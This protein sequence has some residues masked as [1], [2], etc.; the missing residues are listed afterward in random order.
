MSVAGFCGRYPWVILSVVA[1]ALLTTILIM[2]F[3]F[4]VAP[5][6]EH[7]TIGFIILGDI[8]EPGWNASQYAGITSACKELGL[9]LHVRDHV[10]EN[11]GQCPAAIRELANLGCDMIFLCSYTYAKEALPMVQAFPHI[12]FATVGAEVHTANLTAYFVRMYQAR[13]LSGV[14][15][16]LRTTT[17]TIG[18]V[19]AKP[20]TEVNRGI[21]AFTLGVRASNPEARVVVAWTGAWQDAVKEAENVHRLVRDAH[22]DVITYHQD[23]RTVPTTAEAE[24]VFFFGYN[25]PLRTTSERYLGTVLCR[26][27]IYYRNILQRFLKGEMNAVKNHWL[28]MDQQVVALTDMPP[29]VTPALRAQLDTLQQELAHGKLIFVGPLWDNTGRLRCAAGE[30]ISDDTLM[31]NMPWYVVGVT[32]LE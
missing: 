2:I 17:K 23:D 29:S 15:A 21:N 3:T 11:S 25:T 5:E 31:E 13:Y 12:A 14:L 16:G 18:Y 7:P 19:A 4:D 10:R 27:D 24:N 22:A 20:N 28:G 8:Q 32:F 1:L 9:P 6:K 26:W 30:A